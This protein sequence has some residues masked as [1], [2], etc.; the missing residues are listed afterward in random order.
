[1]TA[2]P[3][4]FQ[5]GDSCEGRREMMRIST[6][7]ATTLAL[8]M[9]G[10][11]GCGSMSSVKV[12]P[13]PY[14]AV[15][16]IDESPPKLVGREANLE[17]DNGVLHGRLEGGA[18]NVSITPVSAKGTGPMGAIDVRIKPVARGYD[19][20]G[21]WNGGHVHFVVGDQRTRGH[22]LKQISS[23]DRGYES[24]RF[25]LEKLRNR[26]GYSGIEDCLGEESPI[27][28]EVTPNL[29]GEMTREQTAILL[30]AYFAAPPPVRTL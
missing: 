5:Q 2:A 3:P 24:C 26:A 11:G 16:A 21:L 17:I 19:V 10:L 8:V 6:L 15:S 29:A 28:Y 9:G 20:A 13:S 4:S 14:E 27:R 23:E 22:L 18:Y 12:P 7:E 1:M 25:D 30:L